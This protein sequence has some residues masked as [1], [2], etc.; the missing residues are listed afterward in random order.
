MK[1]FIENENFFPEI[2]GIETSIMEI[3]SLY[4]KKY[5]RVYIF[6]RKIRENQKKI[7]RYGKKGIII[8]YECVRRN[9]NLL[10][11]I[12]QFIVTFFYKKKIFKKIYLDIIISRNSILAASSIFTGKKVIFVPPGIALNQVIKIEKPKNIY[13]EVVRESRKIKAMINTCFEKYVIKRAYKTVVFSELMKDEI[14]RIFN[15]ETKVIYPGVNH[16]KFYEIIDKES[17]LEKYN[18]DKRIDYYVYIGRISEIKNIDILIKAFK[19]IADNRTKLLIVG[20]GD[21]KLENDL[22]NLVRKLELTSYVIFLGKQLKTEELY[23]I[24]KYTV[25][26]SKSESFGQVITESISCGTPAIGF[27]RNLNKNIQVA[28][29]EIIEDGVTGFVIEENIIEKFIESKKLS[30]EKYK[31]MRSKCKEKS[32]RYSWEKFMKKILEL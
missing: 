30:E 17:I 27:K 15:L 6:T 13:K 4:T 24:A 28:F 2:G 9:Y 8:R 26:L 20:D 11:S 23:N 10:I 29:D 25:L 14:K 21:C 12:K 19:S 31:E 3:S 16:Q 32:L 5:D 22:R 1:L 18:L 7:E